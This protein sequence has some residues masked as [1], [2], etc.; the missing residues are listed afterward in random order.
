MQSFGFNKGR[1][2]KLK[3]FKIID[4][5]PIFSSLSVVLYNVSAL[6]STSHVHIFNIIFLIA[7]FTKTVC[8]C[9]LKYVNVSFC[10][11]PLSLILPRAF[12]N[13]DQY[14][15]LLH[16]TSLQKACFNVPPCL[17]D[18]CCPNGVI[19]PYT[20]LSLSCCVLFQLFSH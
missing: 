20:L 4:P 13:V 17:T 2:S 8:C 7:S 11:L 18:L 1:N 14:S 9:L 3:I 10:S 5:L 19:G 16:K 12:L 6:S 15:S